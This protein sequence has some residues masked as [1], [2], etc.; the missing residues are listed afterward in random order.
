MGVVTEVWVGVCDEMLN[1]LEKNHHCPLSDASPSWTHYSISRNHSYSLLCV[2]IAGNQ[3]GASGTASLVEALKEMRN[4][5]KL[6]LGSE[7]W[8][9]VNARALVVMSRSAGLIG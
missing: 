8:A 5:E 6:D 9:V 1:L 4:L 7:C 3:I 2:N